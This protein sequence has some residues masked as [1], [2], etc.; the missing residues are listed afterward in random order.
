[1]QVPELVS[2]WVSVQNMW[3]TLVMTSIQDSSMSYRN[4]TYK[5]I[6]NRF[7]S[8]DNSGPISEYL[9][10]YISTFHLKLS[11]VYS[12]K[13]TVVE[14]DE[15]EEVYIPFVSNCRYSREDG[16]LNSTLHTGNDIII[17]ESDLEE[18]VKAETIVADNIFAFF[19]PQ[20]TN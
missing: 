16:G 11:S 10:P 3:V 13:W 18:V 8:A 15:T 4:V 14:Q 12:R 20:L 9:L 5:S 2:R 17:K 7:G 6:L 1:M 19:D